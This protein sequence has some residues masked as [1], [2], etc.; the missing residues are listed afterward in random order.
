MRMTIKPEY[1][2][3]DALNAIDEIKTVLAFD[4]ITKNDEELLA[5]GIKRYKARYK[6]SLK[7][8]SATTEAMGLFKYLHE[9]GHREGSYWYINGLYESREGLLENFYPKDAI[10]LLQNRA[11][12]G[13]VRAVHALGICE[14]L[15]IGTTQ[16]D[17]YAVAH[18]KRAANADYT[19]A[20]Y[21]LSLCYR[22]GHGVNLDIQTSKHYAQKALNN[23]FKAS[24]RLL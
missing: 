21:S 19:P 4:I 8:A 13:E 14:Y 9:K 12:L 16:N 5:K 10:S 20:F 11:A 7:M 17:A 18:F 1:S 6:D 23:G 2:H 3:E 15:G 22:F 24:E